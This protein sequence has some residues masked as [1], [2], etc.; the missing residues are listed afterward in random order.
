[1]KSK[2]DDSVATSKRR[3]SVRPAPAP[4]TPFSDRVADVHK[5]AAGG[6]IRT[7]RER[8]E[9]LYREALAN[10]RT[11]DVR[12]VVDA[13]DEMNR[14]EDV[15][16]LSRVRQAV[17]DHLARGEV[18]L[19]LQLLGGHA[20]PTVSAEPELLLVR[21]LTHVT[22]GRYEDA[23]R[24]YVLLRGPLDRGEVTVPDRAALEAKLAEE[25]AKRLALEIPPSGQTI[26]ET[27]PP[28]SPAALDSVIA[29]TEAHLRAEDPLAPAIRAAI[30][31]AL[32][33]QLARD[34][35]VARAEAVPLPMAFDARP[36]LDEAL[37][38]DSP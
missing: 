15:A 14:N 33:R 21:L 11:T 27:P 36:W 4:V 20:D 38:L 28:F 22:L 7:A 1:M 5:K 29:A 26:Q 3:P 34:C 24:D 16:R 30:R 12:Q 13:L 32:R 17:E 18:R 37:R 10:G 6:R 2:S 31:G 19:A 35:E 23:D 25:R 9:S 8:L